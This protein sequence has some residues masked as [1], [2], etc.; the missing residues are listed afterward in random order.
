MTFLYNKRRQPPS[1]TAAF[2]LVE[3]I[4]SSA[5]GAMVLAGVLAT[6]LMI[7]RNS[8][9]IVNYTMMEKQTRVA[10]E[11][12]GIDARMASDFT[13][14]WTGNVITGFTLTIP[15]SDLSTTY[16]VTYG[17]ANSTLYVVPGVDPTATTGRKDLV[18]NVTA[19]TFNRFNSADVLIPASTTSDAGVKHI[20]ASVSTRRSGM[21]VAA[22]TQVI[23]STAFT[24]RNKSS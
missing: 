13:S 18:T 19:L 9:R 12:L 8:V 5:L 7:G 16:S 11:Q 21:G 17:Y 6:F 23:R 14:R 3:V 22:A 15:T 1:R 2:T 10:F 4:V 20:Q 24:I